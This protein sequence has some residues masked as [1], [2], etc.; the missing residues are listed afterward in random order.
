MILSSSLRSVGLQRKVWEVPV[1][2]KARGSA[3]GTGKPFIVPLSPQA[4]AVLKLL[5]PVSSDSD[6]V[7]PGESPQDP[8]GHA[9]RVHAPI[10]THLHFA[11][12]G[13]DQHERDDA[14]YGEGQ[15]G[16][17]TSDEARLARSRPEPR[18]QVHEV[19]RLSRRAAARFPL[20]RGP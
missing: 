12:H 11:G 19:H 10:R 7:F 4:V 16:R 15:A 20:L 5:Q 13:H 18:P 17:R 8:R 6:Y 1:T 9:A 14:E 3:E 2:K